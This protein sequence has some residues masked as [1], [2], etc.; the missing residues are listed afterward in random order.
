MVLF[1]VE[2]EAV[3]YSDFVLECIFY[4]VGKS[5]LIMSFMPMK[6]FVIS[7]SDIYLSFKQI[8]KYLIISISTL[9]NC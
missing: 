2:V 1:K 5:V 4:L 9:S 7:S 3:R 6:F 8:Y